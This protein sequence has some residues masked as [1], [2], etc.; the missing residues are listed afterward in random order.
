MIDKRF[1][2]RY[3]VICDAIVSFESGL[4][5]PA[6]IRDLSAEGAKLR[7]YGKPFIKEGDHFYLSIKGKY[8]IK[9]KAE[10]RW[11]NNFEKWV[12]FGAKF[13]E[14]S[15]KDQESLSKLLSEF[16]LSSLNEIYLK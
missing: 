16:A 9:L 14:I 7:I 2:T 6:E 13:V 12:E 10:V 11:I 3:P 1:Y 4:N 5:Y 15:M 8:K